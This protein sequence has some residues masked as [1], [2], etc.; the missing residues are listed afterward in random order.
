MKHINRLLAQ[1]KTAQNGKGIH[2]FAV[3]F[4]FS[5]K[6][7]LSR[8]QPGRLALLQV[9]FL[10]PFFPLCF[11]FSVYNSILLNSMKKAKSLEK[12]GF[13]TVVFC[14]IPHFTNVF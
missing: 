1:V 14:S 5:A 8:V 7:P 12:Q 11:P 10:L 13:F 6:I 9:V 4:S 2:V 3:F